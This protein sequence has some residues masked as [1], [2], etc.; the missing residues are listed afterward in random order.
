ML[1]FPTKNKSNRPT[2]GNVKRH[3]AGKTTL[4][5]PS[6]DWSP[7]SGFGTGSFASPGLSGTPWSGACSVS[8][9]IPL[10]CCVARRGLRCSGRQSNESLQ[11]ARIAA[12]V[13]G[14]NVGP[15][16]AEDVAQDERGGDGVIE[17]SEHRD[18]L[19][20]EIDGGGEPQRA[21]DEQRFR[22]SGYARIACEFFEEDQEVRQEQRDLFRGRAATDH[23]QRRNRD[24][25]DDRGDRERDQQRVQHCLLAA[26]RAQRRQ[27]ARCHSTN[28]KPAQN[29]G[30]VMARTRNSCP[31]RRSVVGTSA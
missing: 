6:G 20:D 8:I 3:D 29:A 21:D 11:R 4:T 7:S 27:R 25:V 30:I 31:T 12:P 13:F 24:D 18:E 15:G 19:R 9:D 28:S 2:C 10:L 1:S 14:D 17:W 26:V 16:F 5:A 22:S 23:V